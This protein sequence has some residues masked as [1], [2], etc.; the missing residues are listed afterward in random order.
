MVQGRGAGGPSGQRT[1]M[2]DTDVVE[3]QPPMTRR[4]AWPDPT[5]PRAGLPA[6][7][8]C[9]VPDRLRHA[10]AGPR[11]PA[12]AALLAV[13]LGIPAL[14]AGWQGDDW[15]HLA[16]LR[17]QG[18]L[19]GTSPIWDLFRFMHG[20]ERDLVLKDLG[21]ITWWSADDLAIGFLR[22]LSA[23]THVLDAA[24]WADS[25]PLQH[26]HSLL[27]AG[28][29]VFSVGVLLRRALPEHPAAAGLAAL[30]FAC[31]DAHALPVGW[32]ANRNALV[33]VA[34]GAA[35]VALHIAWRRHGG[36]HRALGA[37][38]MLALSLAAG[39]SGV[40][41][42]AYV[43]AWQLTADT[44]SWGRR[45]MGVAPAA[46]LV[47]VWR[48]VYDH[49]GY[50]A[51]GSG[52]Y[53]DPGADPLAFA[54]AVAE[55]APILNLAQWTSAP[56]DGVALLSPTA[57]L[58]VTAMGLAATVGVVALLWP[59]L[60]DR[61]E[62]RFLA[63]GSVG[64]LLGP[65]ATFPMDRLLT[66]SGVGMAGL[67][68]LLVMAAAEGWRRMPAMGLALWHG[69]VAGVL[70][71]VRILGG[72]VFGYMFAEGEI[73]APRDA[74]L[75]DQTLVFLT[76]TEFATVYTPT[77]RLVRGDAPPPR[78]V[79]LLTSQL[80]ANELLREDE[81]TLV[82]VPEGGFLAVPLTWLMRTP[83]QPFE[84][85]QE[86]ERV[87]FTAEVRATT[88]DGRPSVVAFHFRVPLEDAGLRFM[89]ATE[90]GFEP[91]TPPPIGARQ[92]LPLTMPYGSLRER[93]LP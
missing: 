16:M 30:F 18:A 7:R 93:G 47:L 59:L 50:G 61:R 39:E 87:D 57:A 60:R 22:P 32:I 67:L 51:H 37:M 84:V 76:G 34:F 43:L 42:A 36:L 33:A 12:L 1:G 6:M 86:A 26:A 45:L 13:L 88:A 56:V 41:A 89:Q 52:L 53:I 74:A 31:E 79:H 85:G 46:A 66:F 54:Q 48:L 83:D 9:G 72:P 17:G 63:L 68:G 80:Q 71:A 92:S 65:C 73:C 69:P 25:A 38:G 15:F 4:T 70:L 44:G 81:D 10:L 24:L 55:R 90:R 58:G 23:L 78:R 77:I 2:A 75:A 8:A 5:K 62:A 3:R 49:L 35:A 20:G 14:T 64:A 82:I 21:L 19:A 29:A 27:W 91:W 11:L 28:L 40:G